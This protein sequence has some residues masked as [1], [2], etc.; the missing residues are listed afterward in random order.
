MKNKGV[1]VG[2]FNEEDIKNNVDKQKLKEI[3][4]ATGLKYCNTEYVKKKGIIIGIKL[5]ACSLEDCDFS[6]NI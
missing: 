2:T 1:F 4:A 6:M 5:W 3:Q